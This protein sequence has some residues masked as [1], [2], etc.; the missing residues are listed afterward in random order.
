MRKGLRRARGPERRKLPFSL[1][2]L[3]PLKGLLNLRE[4]DQL[5]LRT[6]ILLGR[7]CMLRMSEFLTTDKGGG[8]G[9]RHPILLN[10]AEP[11]CMG[12]PTNWG[13][14]VDEVCVYISGSN[15]DWL[16]QGCVRSHARVSPASPNADIFIA[17]AFVALYK[18]FPAKFTKY[19]DRPVAVWRYNFP[20][21]PASVTALLRAAASIGGGDRSEY[22]IHSLRPG[23]PG[24]VPSRPR[25]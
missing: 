3:R 4:A 8:S 21:P 18:E 11:M 17:G 16:N 9:G 2:D 20:I 24:L 19:G 5:I 25:Y 13:D 14:H 10:E 15:T 7:F 23:A 22:S 12:S 6:S 1:E